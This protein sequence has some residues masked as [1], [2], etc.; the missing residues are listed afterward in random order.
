[1]KSSGVSFEK[2]TE[3]LTK[4]VL[5]FFERVR[6]AY[7]S[8]KENPKEYG[9]KWKN[10]VKSIRENF[11]GLGKF[12]ELLKDKI[13]EKELFDEKATDAE[14]NVARKVYEDV[15]RMRFE[16]SEISDPFSK[17]LGNKVLE[18]LMDDEAVFAAFI[19]YALRSHANTLPKKA[20]EE[21]NLKPDEI[22]QNSIGL[23]IEVKDIPLYIIE[24]Y[25]DDKDTKRVEGK[26]NKALALLKEVYQSQYSEER[27]NN[28]KDLDI[29][30]SD[31]EKADVDFLIPNKPMYRVF[32]IED[33][34]EIE[35]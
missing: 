3:A 12:S 19:H 29:A 31:E 8:A 23:D 6:Y 9:K 10:T 21:A 28:L 2:E 18:T 17:Q 33:I 16:T 7:L 34:E 27:W 35:D 22:T 32:T 15:K 26:F 14:S 13:N 11:D 24:H 20:W 5:D 4:R 25:G 1:M 30:K